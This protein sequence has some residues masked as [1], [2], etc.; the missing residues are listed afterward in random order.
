MVQVVTARTPG[1]SGRVRLTSGN[2]A[3]VGVEQGGELLRFHGI[4]PEHDTRPPAWFLGRV[5]HIAGDG[6]GE[7]AAEAVP[8][9]PALPGPLKPR[10]GTLRARNKFR[11]AHC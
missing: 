6:L 11:I 8:R 10:S 9:P 1:G 2:A 4:D 5:A 7:R 3:H